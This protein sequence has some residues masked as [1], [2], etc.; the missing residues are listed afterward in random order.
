MIIY[1]AGNITPLRE[2]MMLKYKANRLFSFYFHGENKEFYDEFLL[3][4][5][6]LKKR[7]NEK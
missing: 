6:H 3:R 7:K 4:M 5:N 1:L 2:Q